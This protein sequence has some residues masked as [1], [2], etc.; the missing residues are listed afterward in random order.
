MWWLYKPLIYRLTYLYLYLYTIHIQKWQLPCYSADNILIIKCK[1]GRHFPFHRLFFY[2]PQGFPE[3]SSLGFA[4]RDFPPSS[5][6][7]AGSVGWCSAMVLPIP[8]GS[9]CCHGPV[10]LVLGFCLEKCVLTAML[11]S[12]GYE[13]MVLRLDMPAPTSEWWF[14]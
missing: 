4:R 2:N 7:V 11:I 5:G 13:A 14:D 12:S 10:S 9:C 8:S 1:R 3:S 6:W